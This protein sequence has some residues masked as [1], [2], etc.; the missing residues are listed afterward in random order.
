M[1][2]FYIDACKKIGCRERVGVDKPCELNK[3][4]HQFHVP[5][6]SRGLLAQLAKTYYLGGEDRGSSDDDSEQ[7][8]VGKKAR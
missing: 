5:R 7:T 2:P 8:E 6:T 3:H 1:G 4:G